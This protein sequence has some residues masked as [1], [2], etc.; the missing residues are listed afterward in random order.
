MVIDQR[1][2]EKHSG[3]SATVR[4]EAPC[5]KCGYNLVGLSRSGP[6]P[7]CG[8]PISKS[9]GRRQTRTL[10]TLPR[11]QQRALCAGAL[12]AGIAVIPMAALMVIFPAV[13]GK[14]SNAAHIVMSSLAL[15]S[16]IAWTG[17]VF[18][19]AVRLPGES[20]AN[21][22]AGIELP[23]G[24]D[25]LAQWSQVAWVLIVALLGTKPLLPPAAL[26][27]VNAVVF[28]LAVV[29][30][31]GL[32]FVCLRVIRL[33]TDIFDERLN[34]RLLWVA[35]GLAPC[36]LGVLILTAAAPVLGGWAIL[37]LISLLLAIVSILLVATLTHALVDLGQ[38][39]GWA[40][41]NS[42]IDEE[43]NQRR[44][45]RKAR[46]DS[47]RLKPLAHTTPAALV[48]PA[49]IPTGTTNDGPLPLAQEPPEGTP[50]WIATHP[51]HRADRPFSPPT[52]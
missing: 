38:T 10:Q 22:V 47:D 45:I 51:P 27:G 43:R 44:A 20:R 14:L 11:G 26:P 52:L 7:E 48:R 1:W 16:S 31:G 40:A 5:F 35:W 37:K 17:G 21:Q 29:G 18:L 4:T 24:L 12:T 2:L 8:T 49:Q 32:V 41:V 42:E 33:S 23:V 6:C 50:G 13:A 34:D 3:R 39:I 30:A 19:L 9:V 15:V 36:L 28:A 25:Q 46:E